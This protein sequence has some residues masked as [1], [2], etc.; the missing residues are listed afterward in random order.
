VLVLVENKPK[1]SEVKYEEDREEG[2]GK[3]EEYTD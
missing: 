1:R 2:K 3:E